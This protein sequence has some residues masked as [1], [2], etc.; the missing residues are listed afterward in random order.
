MI[1]FF[2]CLNN[3]YKHFNYVSRFFYI[4]INSKLILVNNI[5]QITIIWLYFQFVSG[6]F[7][8]VQNSILSTHV[9][10]QFVDGTEAF[11]TQDKL[12]SSFTL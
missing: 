12:F 6:A 3:F 8:V 7:S 5:L 2:N 9:K 10:A 1:L 4:I 11:S